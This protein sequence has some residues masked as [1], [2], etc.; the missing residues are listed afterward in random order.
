MGASCG[1]TPCSRIL[2]CLQ[3]YRPKPKSNIVGPLHGSKSIP[4]H[5]PRLHSNFAAVPP[6]WRRGASSNLWPSEDSFWGF[7]LLRV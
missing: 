6:W 1:L 3:I 5:M 4:E 7:Y 2:L